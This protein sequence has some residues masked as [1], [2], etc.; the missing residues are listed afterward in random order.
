MNSYG[1]AIERPTK[2]TYR[3]DKFWF[4]SFGVGWDLRSIH[5]DSFA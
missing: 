4:D 5:F 3:V 1:A 2:A